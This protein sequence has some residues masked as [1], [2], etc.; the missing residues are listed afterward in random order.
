MKKVVGMLPI[1]CQLLKTK[2][3]REKTK[4]L[5]GDDTYGM[6]IDVM[7]DML[8]S[9]MLKP[10]DDFVNW[11]AWQIEYGWG[12]VSFQIRAPHDVLVRFYKEH[13]YPQEMV[14][15]A[16]YCAILDRGEEE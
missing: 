13:G 1:S 2:E 10:R 3:G 12:P 14:D 16:L 5:L 15:Y 8:K 6:A 7:L 9:S 4:E 11:V